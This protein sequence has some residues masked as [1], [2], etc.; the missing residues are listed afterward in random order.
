LDH[1]GQLRTAANPENCIVGDLGNSA[2]V[3]QTDR[4]VRT[5]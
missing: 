2:T 1:G 3:A 4:L 5:P